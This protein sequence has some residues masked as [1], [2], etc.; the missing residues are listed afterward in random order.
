MT[1]TTITPSVRIGRSPT[2]SVPFHALTEGVLENGDTYQLLLSTYIFPLD[3]QIWDIYIN[4]RWQ[5]SK[6]TI[7]QCYRYLKLYEYS[8]WFANTFKKVNN[9]DVKA[10]KL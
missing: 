2:E 5:G 10:S 6:R 7:D 3:N 8:N 4:H 9:N 1:T